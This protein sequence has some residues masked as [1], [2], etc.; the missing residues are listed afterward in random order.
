MKK[1]TIVDGLLGEGRSTTTGETQTLD[2]FIVGSLVEVFVRLTDGKRAFHLDERSEFV[3]FLAKH[4]NLSR[5]RHRNGEYHR[6]GAASADHA[7]RRPRRR[8]RGYSVI[9]DDHGSTDE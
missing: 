2:N 1:R 4:F 8:T 9:N 3:C 7:T 5:R 6:S